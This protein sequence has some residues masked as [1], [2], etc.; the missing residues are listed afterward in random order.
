MSEDKLVEMLDSAEDEAMLPFWVPSLSNPSIL[1]EF[2]EERDITT[3]YGPMQGIVICIEGKVPCK[4]GANGDIRMADEG[5]LVIVWI[6]GAVMKRKWQRPDPGG[7]APS[8]GERVGIK[9]AGERTSRKFGS[10]YPVFRV[11]VDRPAVVV[12]EAPGGAVDVGAVTSEDDLP[13]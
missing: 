5:D 2:V 1:G 12:D 13:F 9:R 4:N 3:D 8:I 6:K 7:P 11:A 10:T